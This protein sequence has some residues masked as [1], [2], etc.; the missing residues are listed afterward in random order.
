M[1]RICVKCS[2]LMGC[3]NE[4]VTYDCPRWA[5]DCANFDNCPLLSIAETNDRTYGLCDECF[6]KMVDRRCKDEA[7]KKEKEGQKTRLPY[8]GWPAK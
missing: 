1:L 5:E 8:E 3:K 4:L 6:F 7:E 2:V